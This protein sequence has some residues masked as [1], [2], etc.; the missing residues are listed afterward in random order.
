M[1]TPGAEK[2]TNLATLR[3]MRSA[4]RKIAMLTAY[5][6]P[7]AVYAQRAG[8]HALLVGDSLATVLLGHAATRSAPLELMITLA[9]ARCTAR[10]PGG[11]PG[12]RHAV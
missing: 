7:T 2:R 6:Y 3:E 4:G 10:S 8:A 5:D 1:D 12:G 9:E 11:V